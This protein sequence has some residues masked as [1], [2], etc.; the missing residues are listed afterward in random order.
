MGSG[1]RAGAGAGAALVGGGG[2]NGAH[3]ANEKETSGGEQR[4]GFPP[5]T[6]PSSTQGSMA[7]PVRALRALRACASPTAPQRDPWQGTTQRSVSSSPSPLPHLRGGH[8]TVHERVVLALR[9]RGSGGRGRGHGADGEG[10][11]IKQAAGAGQTRTPGCVS[12]WPLRG[13]PGW[14]GLSLGVPAAAAPVGHRCAVTCHHA[15]TWGATLA[16]CSPRPRR[17]WAVGCC[18]CCCCVLLVHA[19]GARRGRRKDEQARPLTH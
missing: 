12:S 15:V 4:I 9:G 1:S 8:A 7:G 17:L 6:P 14:A 2:G 5:G 13:W 16:V 18:C 11:S 19:F 10:A 3:D